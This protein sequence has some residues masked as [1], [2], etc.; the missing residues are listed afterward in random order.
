MIL[1]L[2]QNN[3]FVYAQHSWHLAIISQPHTLSTRLVLK[4]VLNRFNITKLIKC[5]NDGIAL[6]EHEVPAKDFRSPIFYRFIRIARIFVVMW[7]RHRIC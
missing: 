1:K 7:R 2:F 4:I 6:I 5:D 3:V